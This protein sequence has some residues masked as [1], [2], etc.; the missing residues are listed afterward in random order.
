[1]SERTAMTRREMLGVAAATGAGLVL[2]RSALGQAKGGRDG[3]EL[4]VA[5]IGAGT[6]GRNLMMQCLRIPGVRFRAVCDI[7]PFHQKYAS[8]ILKRFGHPVSVHE[9]LAGDNLE[10]KVA[11]CGDSGHARLDA[12]RTRHRLAEGWPGGVL[13]EA[14]GADGCGRTRD[15]EGRTGSRQG[16]PDRHAAAERP[17]VSG[18]QEGR[19]RQGCGEQRITRVGRSAE[20]QQRQ[21]RADNLFARDDRIGYVGVL[22]RPSRSWIVRSAL[23]AARS[24]CV[25]RSTV[26]PSSANRRSSA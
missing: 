17:Q 16:A 25:T 2:G 20:P 15:G 23:A 10:G 13:R 1:V 11:G 19:A 18:S 5:M 6:Q 9:E 21:G 3:D 12:R 22:V 24:S 4:N 26:P 8:A 14:D 7:W